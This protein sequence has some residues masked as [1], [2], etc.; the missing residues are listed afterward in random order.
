[1]FRSMKFFVRFFDFKG[2]PYYSGLQNNVFA[3][4][5]EGI[6]LVVLILSLANSQE[7]CTKWFKMCMQIKIWEIP[8]SNI[9]LFGGGLFS[10]YRIFQ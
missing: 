4:F 3:V 2:W 1:M 8:A 7:K 10:L 6:G 5:I 9:T